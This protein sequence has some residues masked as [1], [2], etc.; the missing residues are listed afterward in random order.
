MS[1][2]G[3]QLRNVLSKIGLG[4]IAISTG[5]VETDMNSGLEEVVLPDNRMEE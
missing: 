1:E 3:N 2:G 5:V 4:K